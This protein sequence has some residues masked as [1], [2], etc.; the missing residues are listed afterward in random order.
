[1]SRSPETPGSSARRPR[2]DGNATR[3]KIIEVAGALFAEKGYTETSSKEITQR[4]GTAREEADEP[5]DEVAD[6]NAGEHSKDAEV[7][8]VEVGERG[9]KQLDGEDGEGAAEHVEGQ[10]ALAFATGDAA[11]ERNRS[12]RLC[13]CSER[14]RGS[15]RLRRQGSG[16]CPGLRVQSGLKRGYAR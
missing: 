5:C 7:G 2:E 11:F 4:A 8:E 13:L 6:S 1:M 14:N 15:S 10:R 3:Q 16:I 9:D 12:R